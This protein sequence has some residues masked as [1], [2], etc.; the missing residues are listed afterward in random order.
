MTGLEKIVQQIQ[1]EAQQA[2]DNVIAQAKTEAAEIVNKAKEEAALQIASIEA[3]SKTDEGN[4]L[5][6]GKSAAALQIR[7]AVLEAKQEIIG[8]MIEKIQKS[9][10]DLPDDKYFA[11]ILKMVTKYALPE[12]G[13]ILFN[14]SDLKRLPSDFSDNI[15]KA[16]PAGL[17]ISKETRKID[18]GF[19]LIYGGVE[20][21]CSFEAL[22]YAARETLQDKVQKLLFS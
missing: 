22:F 2:A 19:V 8:E 21:N 4:I 12:R 18:G 17:T 1:S 11:L 3:Q 6:A 13:E 14:A 5:S 20:E 7:R 16:A 10:Y 15:A 9:I